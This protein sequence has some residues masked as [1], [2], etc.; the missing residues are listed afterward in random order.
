MLSTADKNFSGELH[1]IT[2][3]AFLCGPRLPKGKKLSDSFLRKNC[4]LPCLAYPP[5]FVLREVN[6]QSWGSHQWAQLAAAAVTSRC[7]ELH[8]ALQHTSPRDIHTLRSRGA[9][10]IGLERNTLKNLIILS[11]L[12]SLL[13][14]PNTYSGISVLGAG[15]PGHFILSNWPLSLCGCVSVSLVPRTPSQ[16][17]RVVQSSAANNADTTAL[18]SNTLWQQQPISRHWNDI[19]NHIILVDQNILFE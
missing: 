5:I 10:I 19:R 8:A 11:P 3:F 16:H 7:R 13:Q 14:P 9:E 15:G 1:S 4:E 12:L 17:P 18:Q 6:N 2:Y